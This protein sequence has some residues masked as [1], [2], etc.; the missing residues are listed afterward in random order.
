[1]HGHRTMAGIAV[2]AMLLATAGCGKVAEKVAEHQLGSGSKVKI[3][4]GKVSVNDGKGNSYTADPNGVHVSTPNG[5]SDSNIGTKLPAGWPSELKP[6]ASITITYGISNT[7]GGKS[8]MSATGTTSAPVK[9]VYAGVKKQLTDA[10]YTL[11]SD[12]LST[13][14]GMSIGVLSAKN[15]KYEVSVEVGSSPTASGTTSVTMSIT[16]A[17]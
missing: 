9:D 1:M 4:N 16:S 15:S 7:S 11:V 10:G 6:P 3:S 2:A 14:G 13:T 12:N 17:N 8:T 5:S